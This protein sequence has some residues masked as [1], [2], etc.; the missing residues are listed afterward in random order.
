MTP[1]DYDAMITWIALNDKGASGTYRTPHEFHT[2]ETVK[3]VA[4]LF[5][6]S[7]MDVAIDVRFFQSKVQSAIDQG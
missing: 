4:H 5:K 2:L 1:Q 6:R 7:I 3:M